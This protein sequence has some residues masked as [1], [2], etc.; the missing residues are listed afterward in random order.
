MWNG[1][2]NHEKQVQQKQQQDDLHETADESALNNA[3]LNR[4]IHPRGSE[5]Y[6]LL[7]FF[8]NIREQVRSF[9]QSRVNSVRGIKYNLCVKVEMQRDDVEDSS[10]AAPYFRRRTYMALSLDDLSDHDLNEALQKMYASLEKY[11]REVS[12]LYFKK[13]LKLEIHTVVYKPLPVLHTCHYLNRFPKV[14]AY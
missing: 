12:G 10:V 8:G 11:M 14:I 3:V 9:L 7:T 13:V 5:R 6:D 4:N 1:D 2:K